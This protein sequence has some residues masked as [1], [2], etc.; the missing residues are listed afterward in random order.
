MMKMRRTWEGEGKDGG[1]AKCP[2]DSRKSLA[3][4]DR[5]AGCPRT[6]PPM[7]DP[8][9]L[10]KTSESALPGTPPENGAPTKLPSALRKL[11]KATP[12]EDWPKLRAYLVECEEAGELLDLLP[13]MTRVMKTCPAKIM[14]RL[15]RREISTDQAAKAYTQ[16]HDS[17]HGVRQALQEILH[18]AGFEDVRPPA[19]PDPA[20]NAGTQDP[21]P[22]SGPLPPRREQALKT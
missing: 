17:M 18:L 20:E 22:L 16:L 5:P 14:G 15:G 6:S 21:E 1:L 9:A 8:M 4:P 7:E 11:L 2:P 19:E 3:L 10:P 12:E 13:E